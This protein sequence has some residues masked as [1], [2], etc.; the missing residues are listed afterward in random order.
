MTKKQLGQ[1]IIKVSK[2]TGETKQELARKMFAKDNW[3]WFLVRE[4]AK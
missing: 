2:I 4:A 1:A 3:T